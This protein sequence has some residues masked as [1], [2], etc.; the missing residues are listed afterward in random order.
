MPGA[1]N[2]LNFDLL[3]R[4]TDDGYRAQVLSSPA[5]EA[6]ADFT[7]PLS[8]LELENFA[9]RIGR[10]RRGTRRL[11]TPEMEAVKTLGK[12]L[13]DAVF[14]GNVG[15]CWHSSLTEAEAQNTGLRLRL[16]VADAPALNDIPWEYL[17]NASLNRFL[18][19]SE[20]TPLIRYLDLAERIRPLAIEGRLE[21]LVM[22]SDPIDYP[23][24]DVENEWSRLS[25][26]LAG[27]TDSGQ[28]RIKRLAEARLSVL[29][30]EL[31]HGQYHILHYIGHGGFDPGTQ[32]GV[33]VLRDE[34]G[35]GR[36]VAAEHLATILHDH[37]SLRLVVLNACEG[38][39][40][41]RAD[42]FSGVAQTI[43]QQ[44]IPAVIAMQ[45]EIT[46]TAAI[47]F[48]EEFYAAV[49][50]GHPVDA[51]LSAARKAIFAAGNDTEWG[52]PVLYLRAP[53]GRLFS[54]DREAAQR[55]AV[56]RQSAEAT[57]QAPEER[58][59]AEA[60]RRAAKEE[61]RAEAARQAEEATKS[62]EAARKAAEEKQRAEV[63]R[64]AAEEKLRA[65]L[66]LFAAVPLAALRALAR[67][68]N[69]RRFLRRQLTSFELNRKRSVIGAFWLAFVIYL[70]QTQWLSLVLGHSMDQLVADFLREPRS[71]PPALIALA[72]GLATALLFFLVGLR[73]ARGGS[74][75]PIAALISLAI[76]A[77]CALAIRAQWYVPAVYKDAARYGN[78]LLHGFYI[79]ALSTALLR[80]WLCA[81]LFSGSALRLVRLALALFALAFFATVLQK[82]P[83]FLYTWPHSGH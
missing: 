72:V 41:S 42:P 58:Q 27:L 11:G 29:Q 77:G 53:D 49:A 17:Y 9:L 60:T 66:R 32:D 39:R 75:D 40:T 7:L 2:Y 6:T 55:A 46:D 62:A 59:S 48:G 31:R 50:D 52:I 36:P 25:Q 82:G 12:G 79:A 54:V 80:A 67:L 1:I 63:A 8:E 73:G 70:T 19:L 51:A 38:S 69:H 71:P 5:G 21:I 10:P 83:D 4:R 74:P 33:L 20:S 3:V 28:I 22:I 24:L 47:T 64:Q 68:I 81:P 15:A 61:Q 18:S 78:P 44:G 65:L 57:R 43:V 16:R 34:V 35:R 37:R 45:F 13:Y 23:G 26:A 56:E 14:S 30:R 76:A